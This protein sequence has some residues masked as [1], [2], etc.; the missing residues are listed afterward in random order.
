M[1]CLTRLPAFTLAATISNR[2]LVSTFGAICAFTATTFCTITNSFS[3]E[4]VHRGLEALENE[5]VNVGI[6]GFVRVLDRYG[7]GGR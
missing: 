1:A 5:E 7:S 2:S 6:D 3:F 4:N